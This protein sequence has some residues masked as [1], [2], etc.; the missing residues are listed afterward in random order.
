MSEQ[1]SSLTEEELLALLGVTN[2]IMNEVVKIVAP[3]KQQMTLSELAMAALACK[4][5]GHH[6]E[7]AVMEAEIPVDES[8]L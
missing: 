4:A 2:S 3:G 7:Q 1:K 5:A 8:F 6:F